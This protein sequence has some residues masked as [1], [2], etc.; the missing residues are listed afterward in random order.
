MWL[1]GRFPELNLPLLPINVS[2]VLETAWF[3]GFA[4]AEGHFAVSVTGAGSEARYTRT[5]CGFELIQASA[6]T[7]G[8]PAMAAIASTLGVALCLTSR[9]QYRLRTSTVEQNARLQ[10]YFSQFPMFSSKHLDYLDWLYVVQLFEK[11]EHKTPG[12]VETIKRVSAGMSS[13]RTEY[14]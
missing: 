6:N 14:V 8:R 7:C 4:D 13:R 5:R 3:S 10:Q 9:D 11:S 12:G 2:P 1:S